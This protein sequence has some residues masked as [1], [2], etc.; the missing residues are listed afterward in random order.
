LHRW[1][2]LFVP[3]FS[4]SATYD[5]GTMLLKMGIKDAFAE[6]AD[7]SGLTEDSGLKLSYVS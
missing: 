3:K 4:I 6:N 7:F 2:D 5:L 1:V